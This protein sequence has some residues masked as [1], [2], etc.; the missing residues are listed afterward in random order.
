MASRL[1][2]PRFRR[3][4]RRSL[5]RSARHTPPAA[6]GT[7]TPS[8]ARRPASHLP[9]D[10]PPP[11]IPP[12]LFPPLPT[13]R[14]E[15]QIGDSGAAALA[16]GVAPLTALRMLD[17][18]YASQPSRGARGGGDGGAKRRGAPKGNAAVR[19]GHAE[20]A[21]GG[22]GW[23]GGAEG[24][25]V[26]ACVC[27]CVRACVCVSACA[28]GRAGARVRAPCVRVCMCVC[29]HAAF[30]RAR[31]G[32]TCENWNVRARLRKRNVARVRAGGRR[33][34][35]LR[36]RKFKSI[37][38]WGAGIV[39]AASSLTR[40]LRRS[41]N[42]GAGGAGSSEPWVGPS[43]LELLL[44]RSPKRATGANGD[45]A[46]RPLSPLPPFPS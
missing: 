12:T 1:P 24:A 4:R 41:R 7:C 13:H 23:D 17:L 31:G 29:Y 37:C 2:R 6:T 39:R 26:C 19:R 14:S 27:A 42:I 5:N 45:D 38:F 11:R 40:P 20:G 28:C 30:F 21:R 33:C 18:M 8:T 22:D 32:S 46:F 34:V 43:C 35:A 16:A 25:Q 3:R 36:A 9:H 15:N 44:L 10:Y